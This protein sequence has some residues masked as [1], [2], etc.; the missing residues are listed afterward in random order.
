MP[1]PSTWLNP[2]VLALS[3]MGPLT[4][5]AARPSGFDAEPRWETYRNRLV[6]N[7]LPLTRQAF[8]HRNSR[9]DLSYTSRHNP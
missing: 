7:D 4:T 5:L 1:R 9:D 3:L 8:G 2:A 6:P